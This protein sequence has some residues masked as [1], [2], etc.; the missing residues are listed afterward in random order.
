[1]NLFENNQM[2]LI[3]VIALICL[4]LFFGKGNAEGFTSNEPAPVDAHMQ[5]Q[6]VV[7]GL[8]AQAESSFCAPS[9]MMS[10]DDLLPESDFMEWA[11]LHPG[12]QAELNNRN[13]LTAGHHIG[14]NTVGQSLRNANLQIRSEPPN[15]QVV[16]SP[17]MQ[18]T[19]GPDLNR[20]PLEI[21]ENNPVQHYQMQ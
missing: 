15:P 13:F 17:W 21:G 20:K 3:G 10:S 5:E 11:K 19:I 16:V 18:A 9:P 1:M 12:G 14:I 2:M 7:D 4:Y 6:M 8:A